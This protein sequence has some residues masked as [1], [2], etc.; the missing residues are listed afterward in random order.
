M[1]HSLTRRILLTSTVAALVLGPVA[2][3]GAPAPTM[4]VGA[5]ISFP[6]VDL[7][8]QLRAW[9]EGWARRA[10]NVCGIDPDG[11]CTNAVTPKNICGADPN[12][13]CTNAVTPKNICGVDP[14]GG[15]C[16]SSF[17]RPT[18]VGPRWRPRQAQ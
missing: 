6:G 9:I 2:A 18:S 12:G 14:N 3:L 7:L 10:G 17:V 1:R 5:G 8:A 15:Q 11:H 13:Q 4:F 16:P